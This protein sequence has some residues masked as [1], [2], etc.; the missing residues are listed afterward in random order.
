MNVSRVA[1]RIAFFRRLSL[2]SILEKIQET[3]PSSLKENIGKFLGSG[4]YGET[5]EVDGGDKVLK[6]AIAKTE[7]DANAFM[8]KLEALQA[9]NSD[10]FCAVFDHGILCDLSIPDS[11]YMVKEGMAYYYVMEKLKPIPANEAKIASQVINDLEDLARKPNYEHERKKYMFSKSRQY[12]RDGDI[13]EGGPDPLKKAADLFDR[14]RA[15]G[16]SH[17]DMHSKNIMQNSDGIY[18]LIDLESAKLVK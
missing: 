1:S 15:G 8:A 18:K 14:M 12:K 10:V 9:K 13:E 2:D 16:L 5:Y 3:C 17:R 11:K 7:A 4:Y 6:V